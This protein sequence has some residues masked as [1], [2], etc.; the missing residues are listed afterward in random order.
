[1]VVS[2]A[3]YPPVNQ[4]DYTPATGAELVGH[5]G[6]APVPIASRM[7]GCAVAIDVDRK[8]HDPVECRTAVESNL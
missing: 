1:V 2:I 7:V 4:G 6:G 5:A 3:A 8:H